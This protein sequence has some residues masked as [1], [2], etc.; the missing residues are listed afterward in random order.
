[1]WNSE[2]QILTIYI[3]DLRLNIH[4]LGIEDKR[5]DKQWSVLLPRKVEWI[6]FKLYPVHFM[7]VPFY[8]LVV[9]MHVTIS[10]K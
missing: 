1:M 3:Y 6:S 7:T 9:D 10:V 8:V 5:M 4:S 2:N